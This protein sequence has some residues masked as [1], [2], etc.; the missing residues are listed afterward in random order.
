MRTDY[1]KLEGLL[2]EEEKRVK[3]AGVELYIILTEIKVDL[4]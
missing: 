3:G 1:T 4:L 2:R